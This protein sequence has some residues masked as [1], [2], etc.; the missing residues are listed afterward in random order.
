[1]QAGLLLAKWIVVGWRS[2]IPQIQAE[3]HIEARQATRKMYLNVCDIN[4]IFCAG[5]L[6]LWLFLLKMSPASRT[7]LSTVLWIAFLAIGVLLTIWQEVMRKKV[8]SVVLRA[9]PT[10]LPDLLGQVGGPALPLCYQPSMPMVVLKG[11]RGYS[12]NLAN[13]LAQLSVAYLAGLAAL[14]VFLSKVRH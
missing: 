6:L 10:K 4:R 2:P 11:A 1:M 14:M 5:M 13:K 8:L 3:E 12:V 7:R 9:R